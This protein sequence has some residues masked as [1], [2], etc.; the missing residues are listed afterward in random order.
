[1]CSSD[2]KKSKKHRPIAPAALGGCGGLGQLWEALAELWDPT[3]DPT[4]DPILDPTL[5]PRALPEP[6]R[7]GPDLHGLPVPPELSR[8]VFLTFSWTSLLKHILLRTFLAGNPPKRL[9]K[10]GVLDER[11]MEK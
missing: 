6:P 5:D 1:M 11:S 7:A 10:V 4:L 8:D 3:L 9:S 2:L